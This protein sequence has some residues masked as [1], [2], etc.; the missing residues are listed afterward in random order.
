MVVRARGCLTKPYIFFVFICE[1]AVIN[2]NAKESSLPFRVNSSI[3]HG[4][5]V[6]GY[7]IGHSHQ[8]DFRWQ[9]K[10]STSPWP[11]VVKWAREINKA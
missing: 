4:H 3:D 9:H 1:S 7:N 5:M 8:Y 6:S 10:P 11:S 2:T